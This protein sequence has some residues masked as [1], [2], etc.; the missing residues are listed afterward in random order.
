METVQ[1]F[2]VSL[3]GG[4]PPS[5]TIQPGG[6]ASYALS[7]SPEGGATFPGA[8]SLTAT[9]LPPGAV[10]SFSPQTIAAG[11][12]T[13]NVTLTIQSPAQTALKKMQG[14][15]GRTFAGVALACI[16]L[17]FV[18]RRRLASGRFVLFCV[19]VLAAASCAALLG[20]GGA[21]ASS[22]PGTSQ[23]TPQ[24]YNITV[25]AASGDLSHTT[26]V[27]LTVD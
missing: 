26:T 24:T 27:T 8:V 19:V 13:T 2:Q 22:S 25:T 21:H 23:Q 17:P 12:G 14:E 5:Q 9:G 20:C 1:D 18:R 6:T 7:F 10:A 11:A 15:R 4:N 16:L 3:G